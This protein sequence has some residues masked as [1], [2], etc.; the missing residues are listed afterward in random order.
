MLD[1]WKDS[2]LTVGTLLETDFVMNQPFLAYLSAFGSS[3][4]LDD[5]SV[6][7]NVHLASASQLAGFRHVIGTL[8]SV[9]EF[10]VEMAKIVYKSLLKYDLTDDSIDQALHNAIRTL[11]DEW[12]GRWIERKAL[13]TEFAKL[14]LT[15]V[16]DIELEEP[17]PEL[18]RS[19]VH[20]I[21][22]IHYC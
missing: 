15:G 12:I 22:Y 10:S 18:E 21:P 6:D 20:W 5:G 13:E 19:P 3:Q 4:I 9:D 2:P 14:R 11:R 16:R 8:W 17:E 1:D 7:E